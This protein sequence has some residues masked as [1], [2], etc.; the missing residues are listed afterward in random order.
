MKVLAPLGHASRALF[1]ELIET[2][3]LQCWY[4][5]GGYY[6]IYLTDR[7]LES[8]KEEMRILSRH[9][10]RPEKLSGPELREH[11]PAINERV[12]GGIF[13]PEAATINPYQFVVE[14]AERVL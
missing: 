5:R 7:A 9:A 12:V 6:E 2:E 14:M 8:V 1:D 13:Y 11:E 3:K 4:C 10:F